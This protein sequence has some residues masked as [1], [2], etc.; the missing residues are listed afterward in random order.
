MKRK[1][2]ICF[3]LALACILG[4]LAGCGA[5]AG[6]ESGTKTGSKHET[7]TIDAPYKNVDGFVELVHEKY[8]EINLEVIPYSGQNTTAWM[9]SMLRAGELPDIYFTTMYTPIQTRWPIN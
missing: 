3:A 1:Q 4:M 8:P 6:M 5:K 2:V 9:K 7:I